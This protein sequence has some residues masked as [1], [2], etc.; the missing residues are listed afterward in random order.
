MR[1]RNQ[2]N[3]ERGC[4]Y[5][6]GEEIHDSNDRKHD[7]I[8]LRPHVGILDLWLVLR[9]ADGRLLIVALDG[10]GGTVCRVRGRHACA[11]LGGHQAWGECA[12]LRRT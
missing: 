12:D 5:D 2:K 9:I 3:T 11:G 1:V 8:Q 7:D 10:L 6:R 4:T